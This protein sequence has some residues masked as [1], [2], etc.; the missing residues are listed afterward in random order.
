MRFLTIQSFSVPVVVLARSQ[1]SGPLNLEA[2]PTIALIMVVLVFV[3][4]IYSIVGGWWFAF[5]ALRTKKSGAP[6][7][8]EGVK[9][10]FLGHQQEEVFEA[11][12]DMLQEIVEIIEEV[13]E[14]KTLHL[15][16]A[17]PFLIWSAALGITLLLTIG[18]FL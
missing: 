9:Q 7:I 14:E 17:E 12:A 13:N 11:A 15:S 16:R 18:I 5:Q 1:F 3:G 8:G 6:A 4:F 10:A 2:L